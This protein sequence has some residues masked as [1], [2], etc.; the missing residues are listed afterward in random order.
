MA[1]R[2]VAVLSPGGEFTHRL[3]AVLA[4]RG[5]ELDALVLY[6]PGVLRE[7]RKIRSAKRKLLELPLLPVRATGRL[8]RLRM[9]RRLRH[10]ASTVVFTGPLNSARMAKDLC[11]LAP[12]VLVLAR[13]GLL[14][15]QLL[16]IPREGVLSV[17]PG[18]LPWIRGNSPLAHS[19]LRQVPLGSTAFRVDPGIDTGPVIARRLV[20]VTGT[21][22]LDELRDAMFSLWV[23]M[24][25]DLVAAAAEGCVPAG[26]AQ[27][28]RFPLC[29]TLAETDPASAAAAKTLLERWRPLCDPRDLSL[30]ADAD[31]DF[32]PAR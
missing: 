15:R 13:C 19:L 3:L 10:G 29:P 4:R 5:I 22:T 27:A 26:S 1:H 16:E 25:A 6:V 24:T 2:R 32:L 20:P 31:A 11:A 28:G 9:D 12:D 14:D 23:E 8:L 18:L 17:H 7:W 30:P 21:E